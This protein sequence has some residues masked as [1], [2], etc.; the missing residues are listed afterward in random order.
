MN[1][2]CFNIVLILSLLTLTVRNTA[3]G[4]SY[5]RKENNI[6]VGSVNL[7]QN[8]ILPGG[9][10]DFNSGSPQAYETA[11]SSVVPYTDYSGGASVCDAHGNLLFYTDGTIIWNRNHAIMPGGH[12]INNNGNMAPNTWFIDPAFGQSAFNRDGVVIIPMPGSSHKYYVFSSPF[13]YNAPF[14][15]PIF[16]WEGRIY[17]TVV[18]MELDNGLGDIVPGQRGVIIADA[19]AGNMHAV[20]GE[21]CNY[22]LL[23]YHSSGSYHAYNISANGIDTANPVISTLSPLLSPYIAELNVSPD[24]RRV[25]MAAEDEVQVSDFDPLTGMLSNDVLYGAQGTRFVAFSPNSS[26]LYLSG[27]IGLRQYDLTAPTTPFTLLTMNNMTAYEFDSPLRLGPDGKIYF[28]YSRVANNSLLSSPVAINQPDIFG[29]GCQA[30]LIAGVSLP[31]LE[32]FCQ[33]L[34]NE[35]PVLVYDTVSENKLAPL[36]FNTP[37]LLDPGAPNGT[38]YRWMVNNS[39]IAFQRQGDGNTATLTAAVPGTYAVQYFTANPCALHLDTFYVRPVS[40]SLYLGE[41]IFSCDGKAVDLEVKVSGAGYEWSDG[42]LEPAIVANTSGQYWVKVTKEGCS[43]TDTIDVVVANFKQDLGEDLVRCLEGGEAPALLSAE[44]P[45][46]ADVLWSNGSQEPQIAVSDTGLYWVKVYQG[47]CV[48]TDT[49]SVTQQYCECPIIFP[50]AFSPN[51]D[52]HNDLFLPAYTEQCPVNTFK[53]Q[54]FN[55]WGTMIYVSYRPHEGWDGYYKGQP[56]EVG[57]YMYRI[58]MKLGLREKEIVR[59][60]DFLLLR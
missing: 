40:F 3:H 48:G 51:A 11:Y 47:A 41:N 19:M 45:A 53:M 24:R 46:G 16:L 9:A 8:P 49:I 33:S 13:L 36:C 30:T 39:G 25:A 18:D 5:L 50:N 20:I 60:G 4:Q 34:P 59:Q 1:R 42:S 55:K 14:T 38:D 32:V 37:A 10:I 22:W 58:S 54:I 15:T 27:I 26:L 56:A 31:I 28:V 44:V 29:T 17:C 21:D 12:D 2:F 52:G 6:W 35:V 7:A 57:T 43:A 23:A